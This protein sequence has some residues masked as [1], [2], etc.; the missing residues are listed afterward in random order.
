MANNFTSLWNMC[1][2]WIFNLLKLPLPIYYGN[3]QLSILD[4]VIGTIG[5]F[6]SVQL[7][8]ALM[9]S[10]FTLAGNQIQSA[11]RWNNKQ[12]QIQLNNSK[13]AELADMRQAAM[14]RARNSK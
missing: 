11:I 1:F 14:L 12:K 8:K 9:G 5:I 3:T 7:I 4:I 2:S 10:S 13:K 6:T